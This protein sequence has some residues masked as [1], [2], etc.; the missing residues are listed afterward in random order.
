MDLL[1]TSISTSPPKAPSTWDGGQRGFTSTA[2]PTDSGDSGRGAFSL[3]VRPAESGDGRQ[4]AS[5]ST[6]RQT[7][8]EDG[9]QGA[10]SLNVRPAESGDERQGAFSSTAK[11]TDSGDGGQVTFSLN[12]RPA[13][14]GDGGQGASTS[15][16]TLADFTS[17][18]E[19]TPLD[20][21]LG[22]DVLG[23]ALP[24][25]T[26][27]QGEP[28]LPMLGPGGPAPHSLETAV[29]GASREITSLPG[30][31]TAT[32]EFVAGPLGRGRCP[33]LERAGFSGDRGRVSAG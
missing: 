25:K 31:Q 19:R 28:P 16:A 26:V 6:A 11:P 7:D 4:R 1:L 8:F 3:N 13:E 21:L 17:T 9:G 33:R 27:P 18:V 2:R 32:G 5:S 30:R 24:V 29:E 14:S 22:A 15:N 10:S 23:N 20:A 12:V